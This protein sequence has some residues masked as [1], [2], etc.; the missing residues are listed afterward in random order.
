MHPEICKIGPLTIY[1]YGLMLVIAFM[2]ST[3][4]AARQARRNGI[5]PDI[6]FN[7]C[8]LVF[9]T[10]I[11]GARIFYVISNLSYYAHSPLEI[12]MLQKGGLAWFGG[13]IAGALSGILYLKFKRLPI[14]K[15]ADLLVPFVALG[16]AFGRLGCF[17]NGCCFGKE[18][19]YGIYSPVQEAVLIPTQLYSSLLLVF[20]F[21]ILRV[22]QERPHKEGQIFF[23]Y[24][25]LYCAKR[26]F[27]EFFRGDSP[28]F[29]FQLTLF[30]VI[31]IAIFII[32]LIGLY[33][34][35]RI[36]GQG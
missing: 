13:L 19:S 7:L 12:I 4:L 21:I 30:Q 28:A 16:Q 8:F 3:F 14:F 35:R 22:L 11:A 15:I 6:I 32:A 17:L 1:S 27:I 20:I 31:S 34:N 29:L 36:K 9:I 18:S 5:H 2:V 10:G 26:F 25:L 24:L 23:A 33:L